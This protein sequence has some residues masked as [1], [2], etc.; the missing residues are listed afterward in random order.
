MWV[1]TC[2]G[3]DI[4]DE[5]I[6]IQGRVQAVSYGILSVVARILSTPSPEGLVEE[7]AV[8]Q[9]CFAWFNFPV[10]AIPPRASYSLI[11]HRPDETLATDRDVKQSKPGLESSKS[12]A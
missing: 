1:L 9:V 4:I 11:Y 12:S 5:Q 10:I 7:V 3:T 6:K 2:E 8:R